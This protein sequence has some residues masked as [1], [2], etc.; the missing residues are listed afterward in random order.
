MTARISLRVGV[1]FW[2]QPEL[3]DEML[4][5]LEEFSETVTEVACSP[6]SR[7]RR[8]RW[9]RSRGMRRR[10]RRPCRDFARL[11][12]RRG[13]TTSPPS[14]IWMK[15]WRIRCASRG[16]TWSISADRCRAVA[17]A[18]PTPT[19][20]IISGVAIWRWRRRGLISSGWMTTC[21]WRATRRAS[22]FACFC[23]RC[24]AR[25]AA[26]TGTSWSRE[27]LA[28]AFNN[29]TREARLALRRQWLAHNRAVI[30]DLLAL[31][32]AAVDSVDPAIPLGLMTGEMFL[33][34]AG[35]PGV[36]GGD[37]RRTGR[38]R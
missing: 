32:R 27:A 21:A 24:L 17:T 23:P 35:L 33:Q 11:G 37:G 18:P 7:T 26:E 13:S 36:D 25:F 30:G 4:S 6:A 29:G 3:R 16:S 14:G 12:S 8:C 9:Q 20:R 15:T 10:W 31:I 2:L 34:R 19:C 5:M 1:E 38:M 28:A 22:R